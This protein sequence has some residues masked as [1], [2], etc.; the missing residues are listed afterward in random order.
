MKNHANGAYAPQ[1]I[2]TMWEGDSFWVVVNQDIVMFFPDEEVDCP[3]LIRRMLFEVKSLDGFPTIYLGDANINDLIDEVFYLNGYEGRSLVEGVEMSHVCHAAE[4]LVKN[5]YEDI[6][7]RVRW[8]DK[9]G[10]ST[11]P[12][13][14]PKPIGDIYK[15]YVTIHDGEHEYAGPDVTYLVRPGQRAAELA[16]AIAAF[17]IAGGVFANGVYPEYRGWQVPG[18]Y[19][20][21]E[22][23][24]YGLV[25]EAVN[26]DTV[27]MEISSKKV[28]WVRAVSPAASLDPSEVNGPVTFVNLFDKKGRKIIRVYV[29]ELIE[30]AQRSYAARFNRKDEGQAFDELEDEDRVATEQH[31]WEAKYNRG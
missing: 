29:S 7:S 22:S 24:C 30:P 2:L 25:G 8:K 21:A 15:T 11:L 4:Y 17:D 18:D 23:S 9:E 19:R 5:R 20:I 28:R 14:S 31:G 26:A 6:L 27:D 13:S 3:Q 1:I 12:P 16:E 10:N